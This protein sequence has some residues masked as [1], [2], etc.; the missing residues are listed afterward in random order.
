MT[1]EMNDTNRELV[2]A[3]K[4]AL[5]SLPNTRTSVEED[6]KIATVAL[7]RQLAVIASGA[8]IDEISD[9]NAGDWPLPEDFVLLA[10]DV[11]ATL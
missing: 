10:N 7:L 1:Y 9:E 4:Q 2:A 6:A 8:E 5:E 11:E 3:V